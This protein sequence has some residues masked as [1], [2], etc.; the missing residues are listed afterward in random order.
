MAR[1]AVQAVTSA[2]LS[3]VFIA[4]ADADVANVNLVCQRKQ[5]VEVLKDIQPLARMAADVAK[6]LLDGARVEG[7]SS[8]SVDGA[9]IPAAA[10]RVEL[11]TPDNVKAQLVDAGVLAAA[12]LPACAFR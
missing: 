7:G 1:G 8:V 4:G 5:S 12:D 6:Q 9:N 10:L 3:D 11:I 2:G